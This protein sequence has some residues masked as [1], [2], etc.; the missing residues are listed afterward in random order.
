MRLLMHLRTASSS[1]LKVCHDLVQDVTLAQ[2]HEHTQIILSKIF[3]AGLQVML[4]SACIA[5][6]SWAFGWALHHFFG[7]QIN[8]YKSYLNPA[9][10]SIHE[11]KKRSGMSVET[12]VGDLLNK[13]YIVKL[14]GLN[15]PLNR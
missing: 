4:S 1:H 10:G 6:L 11:N 14:R 3:L 8:P 15:K 9:C 5:E 13:S 7:V 12:N 2:N